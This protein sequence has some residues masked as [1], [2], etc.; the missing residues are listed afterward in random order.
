M[1]YSARVPRG[2]TVALVGCGPWGRLILRD[3]RTLGAQVPVVA[4]SPATR[5][6]AR[7][8][9]A[10]TIV[11]SVAELPEIDGAVVAVSTVAHAE[12][13]EAL[14]DR[15]VPLFTE[16][17]LAPD[18]DAAE[19]L[20]AAAP[21]RLFV[22]DKWRYHPGIELLAE[23]ARSGELGAVT[24]LRLARVSHG[25]PHADV[26]PIWILA[27]HDLSIVLEVLGA[28]PPARDAV[29][30]WVGGRAEG[31]VGRLGDDPWVTL[32]VSSTAGEKR[33]ETRLICEAGVA[34]LAGGYADHV[35]VARAI[36]GEPERRPV[37]DDMPLLRELRA[38][39]AHLDGGPPPR[40]SAAE[41]AEIV[42]R[43]SELRAL[44][45]LDPGAGRCRLRGREAP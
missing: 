10:A 44:A 43:V 33:R 30:E 19:R 17:P 11:G 5:A 27:P 40:S 20:A 24:G 31:L 29:V 21:D 1:A 8:G 15:G 42:R 38:F 9:G 32:D 2:P 26:D 41:G 13:I 23:I 4:R 7:E 14:L 45:G 25:N 34:W 36:G 18:L 16:K 28:I 12:V 6:R 35:G 3:L 37:P 22:M 39:L